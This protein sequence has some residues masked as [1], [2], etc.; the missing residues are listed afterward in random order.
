M[1][2]VMPPSWDGFMGKF[3]NEYTGP[4]SRM[5]N[6]FSHTTASVSTPLAWHNALPSCLKFLIFEQ[7]G[8]EIYIY[9][10]PYKLCSWSRICKIICMMPLFILYYDY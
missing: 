5:C 3:E 4:A 9:V 10:G 1:K 8:S 6:P 2:A 7:G